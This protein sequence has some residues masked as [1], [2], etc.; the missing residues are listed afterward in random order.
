MIR[1]LAR[2]AAG[3]V[4]LAALV[5]SG[6]GY[7]AWERFHSPFR[8]WAGEELLVAV[9]P[10]TSVRSILDTLER[11]GVLEDARL[12]RLFLVHRLGDP[13]LLA[14]EYRFEGPLSAPEVLDKLR[15][16]EV[17]THPV[18]L[19]EGLTL[20]ETVDALAAAGFGDREVFAR[21]VRKVGRIEDLDPEA[22]NLEGY[23]YPETY[24]FARGTSE[25][26]IVDTLVGTFRKRYEAEVAPLLASQPSEQRTG[27]RGEPLSLRQLV[28]LA[29]IV[30]RETQLDEERPVVASVYANRLRIGMGLYAD[31]TIIYGKKLEGT[32]DGNLRRSDLEADS[33][34]NTYRIPG[35][36]PTPICSPTLA[37]LLAA[38]APAETPYLYFV[39]RNDGT[40]VF[41]RSKKEHDRN[42]YK[43][44]KVYWRERWARERAERAAEKAKAE[45]GSSPSD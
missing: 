20:D 27:Q 9:A 32:W 17:V 26:E 30:E 11:E 34:Y 36:P 12:A 35:L 1:R 44:Q 18:T 14:G 28:K 15:R 29:S 43:W 5:A 31:P 16:G 21:E 45:A 2:W 33:P 39:S 8:E 13:P 22:T 23:L 3:L 24:H 42:V 4:L 38:V 19:I 10:G 25:A 41:A 37:S 7:A 6:L 40:H